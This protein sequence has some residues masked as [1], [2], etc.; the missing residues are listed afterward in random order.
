MSLVYFSSVIF[1]C[2]CVGIG[3][4]ISV[5]VL[6]LRECRCVCVFRV[7]FIHG[8]LAQSKTFTFVYEFCM[9]VRVFANVRLRM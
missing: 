8:V 6:V 5:H 2:V 7:T 9:C 4:C 1:V 3:V